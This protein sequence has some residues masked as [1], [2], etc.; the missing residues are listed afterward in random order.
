MTEMSYIEPAIVRI[1]E[2]KNQDLNKS[3]YF[4]AKIQ[5]LPPHYVKLLLNLITFNVKMLI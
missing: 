4:G 3:K 1:K 2:I 5:I